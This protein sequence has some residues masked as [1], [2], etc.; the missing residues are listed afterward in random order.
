MTKRVSHLLSDKTKLMRLAAYSE[1]MGMWPKLPAWNPHDLP[2]CLLT[3]VVVS[4]RNLQLKAGS[5]LGEAKTGKEGVLE[6]IDLAEDMGVELGIF[7]MDYCE[8]FK[9]FGIN[10]LSSDAKK[11]A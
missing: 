7:P 8:D 11:E 6:F 4:L 10:L 5:S 2:G 9:P 1:N 3:A